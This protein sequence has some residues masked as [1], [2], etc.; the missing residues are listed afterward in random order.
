MKVSGGQ[1]EFL[2]VSNCVILCYLQN[3]RKLDAREKLVFYSIMRQF[4]LE[5]EL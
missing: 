4:G 3:S 2:W 1:C 5:L